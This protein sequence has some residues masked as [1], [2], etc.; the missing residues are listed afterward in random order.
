MLS[1]RL[2]RSGSYIAIIQE[3]ARYHVNLIRGTGE[4]VR[5]LV[6]ELNTIR[7]VLDDAENR[8][9]KDININSWLSR[10]EQTSYQMEDVL[11]KWNYALVKLKMEEN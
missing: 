8:R 2:R 7:N 5:S 4:E 9:F 10:L 11:D 6:N 1:F 3:Q